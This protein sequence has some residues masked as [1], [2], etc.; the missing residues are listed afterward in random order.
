LKD[1]LR[2]QDAQGELEALKNESK[3]ISNSN[4]HTW[5][6]WPHQSSN[7]NSF[8]GS[9][10]QV[11]ISRPKFDGEDDR[12]GTIW[13]NKVKNYFNFYHI[14]NEEEKTGIR[15]M[16]FD[17]LDHYII[18][19]L[20]QCFMG[21]KIGGINLQSHFSSWSQFGNLGPKNHL[22]Y[23][24]SILRHQTTLFYGP[25]LTMEKVTIFYTPIPF[26]Q[27]KNHLNQSSYVKFMPPT[28]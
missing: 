18:F 15:L 10:H 14:H 24:R 16:H 11:K 9:A 12:E 5:F 19:H 27:C 17:K 20:S 25:N 6:S 13:I 3:G 7:S 2:I 26:Q 23:S 1:Q 22:K 28:S 4:C 21:E 8:N